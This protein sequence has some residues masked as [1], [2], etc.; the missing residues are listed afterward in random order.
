MAVHKN[1]FVVKK[2][3]HVTPRNHRARAGTHAHCGHL[4]APRPSQHGNRKVADLG[5]GP[6]P[7]SPQSWKSRQGSGQ[8]V[9]DEGRSRLPPTAL[10]SGRAVLPRAAPQ[11][12]P[13]SRASTSRASIPPCSAASAAVG[14]AA[15]LAAK[16]GDDGGSRGG[17]GH[18]GGWRRGAATLPAAAWPAGPARSLSSSPPAAVQGPSVAEW[19]RGRVGG[20]Q[21]EA[22]EPRHAQR[23]ARH[24]ARGLVRLALLVAGPRRGGVQQGPGLR[25][26]FA[27]LERSSLNKLSH[28]IRTA[29]AASRAPR[30]G[31]ARCAPAAPATAPAFRPPPSSPQ[32]R[33]RT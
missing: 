4:R 12:L 17:Q 26:F 3:W 9:N 5:A 32:D 18:G 25:A 23:A 11:R 14:A 10:P 2:K 13:T 22:R 30:P 33:S 21:G 27:V 6:N 19:A 1:R 8:L 16:G 7:T 31:S 15:V 29:A 24:A 28:N 20:G